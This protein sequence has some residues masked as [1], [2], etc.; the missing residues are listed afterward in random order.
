ML[1]WCGLDEGVV[2][3]PMVD[4]VKG[5]H[6]EL[7]RSL[8]QWKRIAAAAVPAEV[9]CEDR[10]FIE[11]CDKEAIELDLRTEAASLCTHSMSGFHALVSG[12]DL[13][14]VHRQGDPLAIALF[15]SEG[16][17]GDNNRTMQL[18]KSLMTY[19]RT[20]LQLEESE[21]TLLGTEEGDY[22]GLIIKCLDR[23]DDVTHGS[24]VMIVP[25]AEGIEMH[26]MSVRE[27]IP[28]VTIVSQSTEC[29]VVEFQTSA[30]AA[31]ALN[32]GFAQ[33]INGVKLSRTP[34]SVR[35]QTVHL[36]TDDTAHRLSL[37][38]K[39]YLSK[40][41]LRCAARMLRFWS[42]LHQI[43]S[44][45]TDDVILTTLIHYLVSSDKLPFTNPSQDT[46]SNLTV[47][48]PKQVSEDGYREVM[49]ILVGYFKYF[50]SFPWDTDAVQINT[51]ELRI[52]KKDLGVDKKTVI[53]SLLKKP[54]HHM[55]LQMCVISPYTM[56]NCGKKISKVKLIHILGL[57]RASLSNLTA[58]FSVSWP[59]TGFDPSSLCC[60]VTGGSEGMQVAEDELFV[61]IQ[62]GN[63]GPAA[64]IPK[65]PSYSTGTVL[66]QNSEKRSIGEIMKGMWDDDEPITPTDGPVNAS[67]SRNHRQQLMTPT[68]S[69]L[70]PLVSP[71]CPVS[72]CMLHNASFGF[73]NPKPITPVKYFAAH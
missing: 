37:L 6:E 40:P 59:L 42:S 43:N 39:H 62:Y 67:F 52:P 17:Q 65:S 57:Y 20:M 14:G 15:M 58:A 66:I 25:Y 35:S 7:V 38:Y 48:G 19:L 5:Q 41:V 46:V 44:Y 16:E 70:P 61:S 24:C 12:L 29:I 3:L 13:A 31:V 49:S 47:E 33:G 26:L 51:S 72:P 68:T 21:V 22:P 18:L 64:T 9:D 10:A 45:Y 50:L 2:S 34:I 71:T 60:E 36:T 8:G 32:M 1:L 63:D 56:Q 54:E 53:T 23:Q 28:G 27:A 73:P 11:I 4:D 69:P 55:H 30:V